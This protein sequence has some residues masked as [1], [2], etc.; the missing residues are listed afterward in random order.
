[1]AD[2]VMTDANQSP[3]RLYHRLKPY[4]RG[5]LKV[6]NLHRYVRYMMAK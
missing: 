5:Y 2:S 1:M 3:Y 6:D 4:R